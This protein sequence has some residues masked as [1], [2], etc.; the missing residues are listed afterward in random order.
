MSVTVV[1]AS[2]VA[3][4]LFDEP[5]A[6]PVLAM[7][8]GSLKAPNLL[9]YELASVCT[10]KLARRG[11]DAHAILSRYAL[12]AQLDIELTEPDWTAL[13]QLAFDWTLSAYDAAYLQLALRE[14]A[15]LITLDA[16]LAAAYDKAI[17]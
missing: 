12:F 10:T 7:I 15:P 6:A 11:A 3:A 2:V 9:R 4:V 14:H 1:D 16:Q 5:K 13:P 8:S 17:A